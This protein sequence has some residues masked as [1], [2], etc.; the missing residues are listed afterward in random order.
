MECEKLGRMRGQPA[1]SQPTQPSLHPGPK[2]RPRTTGRSRWMWIQRV[3]CGYG[4]GT[5]DGCGLAADMQMWMWMCKDNEYHH[6]GCFGPIPLPNG[7]VGSEE[8][9]HH[10]KLQ[11][12]DNGGGVLARG[13]RTG[14]GDRV[15]NPAF[16]T[17]WWSTVNL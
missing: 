11:S 6:S 13:M 5:D 1:S 8:E 12:G 3:R 7:T 9:Y 16:P 10:Q 15:L 4:C 17:P 2:P 14:H